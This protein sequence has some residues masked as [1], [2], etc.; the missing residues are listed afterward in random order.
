[1]SCRPSFDIAVAEMALTTGDDPRKI[2]R[3]ANI[4][5]ARDSRRRDGRD[6]SDCIQVRA[7]AQTPIPA[8]TGGKS[9][10]T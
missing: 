1:M 8:H 3:F 6:G 7:K 4:P 2:V 9:R 5:S 10:K